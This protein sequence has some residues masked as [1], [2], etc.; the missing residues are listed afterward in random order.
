MSKRKKAAAAAMGVLAAASLA[1]GAVIDDVT[2]LAEQE[3]IISLVEDEIEET[4]SKP[5][6]MKKRGM[7]AARQWLLSLPAAVRMLVAI[8]LWCIG[9]VIETGVSAL[10]MGATAPLWQHICA[11]LCLGLL[12]LVNFMV[13]TKAAFPKCPIRK[14]LRLRNFLLP[15]VAALVLGAADLALPTVWRSYDVTTKIIWRVGSACLLAWLCAS[16][17]KWQGKRY[18]VV[19]EAPEMPVRTPVEQEAWRLAD[20]VCAPRSTRR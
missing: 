14:I 1:T 12:L 5:V 3:P 4:D 8:P 16:E 13:S 11:W 17:L 7:A 10:W 2:V 15:L 20:T 19:E 18:A 9:W 6:Q